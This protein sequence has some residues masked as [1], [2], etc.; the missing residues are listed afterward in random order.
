MSQTRF[1][2]L[3]A[4]FSRGLNRQLRSAR[5]AIMRLIEAHLL[6]SCDTAISTAR[7]PA[8]ISIEEDPVSYCTDLSG[9]NCA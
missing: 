7:I 6:K 5:P 2:A 8:I 1:T 9:K 3:E 4:V